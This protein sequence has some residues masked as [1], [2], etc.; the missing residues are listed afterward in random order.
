ME[1]S[2]REK[3]RAAHANC[4]GLFLLKIGLPT[5]FEDAIIAT[6]IVI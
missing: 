4:T 2:L 1:I 3:L 5:S 6:Q